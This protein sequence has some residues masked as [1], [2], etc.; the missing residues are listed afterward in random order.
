MRRFVITVN[1]KAYEVEVEEVRAFPQ[2]VPRRSEAPPAQLPVAERAEEPSRAQP[3]PVSAGPVAG[4][5]SGTR[6]TAPMPG[7]IVAVKI[8]PGQEVRRGD[9]LMVLEA[10]KMEN[11]IQAPVAG[12]ITEISVSEGVNVEAG[13]L[14]ACIG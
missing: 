12:S 13:A 2:P 8:G 14:L 10:M 6:V 5:A 3:A 9:V 1:G 4:G 11:E 7:R